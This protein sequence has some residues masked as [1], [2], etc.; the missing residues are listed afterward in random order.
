MTISLNLYNKI[1][2]TLSLIAIISNSFANNLHSYD[3]QDDGFIDTVFE[4]IFDNNYVKYEENNASALHKNI[5]KR[6]YIQE[7][8]PRMWENWSRWSAC[9]VTCG[10]GIIHRSRRCVSEGCAT[11]EKEEQI[12]PCTLLPCK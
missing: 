5:R 1:C 6:S 2:V 11:N 4:K 10:L 8:S 3:E 7:K 12:K 9:S